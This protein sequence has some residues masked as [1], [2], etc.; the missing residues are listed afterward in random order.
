M[1]GFGLQHL[2]SGF[3][4]SA[5]NSEKSSIGD[6]I[7]SKY[8]RKILKSSLHSDFIHID[9]TDFLFQFYTDLFFEFSQAHDMSAGYPPLHAVRDSSGGM[10]VAHSL[11]NPSNAAIHELPE[12]FLKNKFHCDLYLVNVLRGH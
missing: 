3:P 12:S 5:T 2:G 4:V 7:Y 6:F 9:Y 1:G 10:G 8:T 11:T